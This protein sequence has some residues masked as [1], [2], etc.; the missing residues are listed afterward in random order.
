MGLK[1]IVP[2][3]PANEWGVWKL[4][5]WLVTTVTSLTKELS[6]LWTLRSYAVCPREPGAGSSLSAISSPTLPILEGAVVSER[7]ITPTE[8][9]WIPYRC[10]MGLL[11]FQEN[12]R[13]S[14]KLLGLA[15]ASKGGY[16]QLPIHNC[17]L[18]SKFKLYTPVWLWPPYWPI[19][20]GTYWPS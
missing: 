14:T 9:L 3:H 11:K 10:W 2:S 19:L 5:C 20:R 6:I 8:A 1:E 13:G 18:K 15:G 16:S 12:L 7:S 4:N 17:P